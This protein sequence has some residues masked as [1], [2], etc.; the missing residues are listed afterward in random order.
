[1]SIN[2]SLQARTI[3]V[4]KSYY[5]GAWDFA[6]ALC[7]RR[8]KDINW[9]L[10]FKNTQIPNRISASTYEVLLD[11]CAEELHE[12]CF[13]LLYGMHIDI[14]S[15]N[16][17]GYLA[18]SSATL[19]E[20]SLIVNRYGVLVSEMGYL[21]IGAVES[22]SN[23]VKIGW[24]PH[25]KQANLSS[26]I[27]DAV[28]A[29]WIQFGKKFLNNQA[30]I[31]SVYLSARPVNAI[32]YQQ[33]FDCPVFLDK[34]ENYILIDKK[35]FDSRLRQAE[36]LVHQAIQL[37]A[38]MAVQQI[39]HDTATL[40]SQIRQAL[41][42]LIFNG[43]ENIDLV[44]QKFNLTKRSLQRHLAKENMNYRELLDDVKQQMVMQLIHENEQP[45][46]H[47]SQIVGFNDQSSFS[48]AFKRWTGKTPVQYM[49]SQSLD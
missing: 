27:I 32:T 29:G 28:L 1:M 35:Y 46:I 25:E 17:L 18:M 48:R 33:A 22:N 47:I 44:A 4:A 49:K 9:L 42:Q 15:F 37:Q 16:L 2:K 10:R 14:S 23:L 26:Q 11:T 36:P 21:Q 8:E 39:K 43:N 40:S 19:G 7:E 20:A 30:K 24:Q 34:A 45:L 13:G 41:P 38:D 6:R 3:T 5:L 31:H 12:P